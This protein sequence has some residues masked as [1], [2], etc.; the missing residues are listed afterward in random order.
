MS[1]SKGAICSQYTTMF[2]SV[3]VD[4]VSFIFN[5]FYFDQLNLCKEFGGIIANLR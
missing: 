2:T 4:V 3:Y 1:A 5:V